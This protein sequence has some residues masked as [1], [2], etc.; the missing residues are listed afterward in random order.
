MI[1]GN[2]LGGDSLIGKEAQRLGGIGPDDVAE[3]HQG[4]ANQPWGQV[5]ARDAGRRMG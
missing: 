2:D 3:Q 4:D 1:T 5:L